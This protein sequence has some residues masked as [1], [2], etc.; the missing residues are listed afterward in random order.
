M[1]VENSTDLNWIKNQLNRNVIDGDDIWEAQVLWG[2]KEEGDEIGF[3]V[4]EDDDE[5]Y[6]EGEPIIWASQLLE[7]VDYECAEED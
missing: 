3:F 6:F 2:R 7:M 1:Y 5:K 4:I